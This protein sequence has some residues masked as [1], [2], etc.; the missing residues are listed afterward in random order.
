MPA[1]PK[2]LLDHQMLFS[3]LLVEL[4]I[5]V[6][7]LGLRATLGEAWRNPEWAEVLKKRSGR[8]DH[9]GQNSNHCRRL[10]VD[11]NLFRWNGKRW[12]WLKLTEAHAE[13]GEW[14]KRLHPLCRWGGDF[15][16]GNHYSLEYNGIR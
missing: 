8:P 3:E 7:E 1:E 15:G 4:L 12:E 13:L 11:L 16:D 6:R 5:R 10:A 2:T 9:P 14:W